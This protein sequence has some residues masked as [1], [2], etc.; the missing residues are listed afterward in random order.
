MLKLGI[1][2]LFVIYA[3]LR[4]FFGLFNH[5]KQN[6]KKNYTQLPCQI[7]T[8]T[9]Q[10]H[11]IHIYLCFIRHLSYSRCCSVQKYQTVS[12]IPSLLAEQMS[13][14]R[15]S[16]IKTHIFAVILMLIPRIFSKVWGISRISWNRTPSLIIIK[17]WNNITMFMFG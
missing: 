12:H 5:A 11:K 2:C 15:V 10:S 13:N 1:C 17:T 4:V 14:Q 9:L 7:S 16:D 8:K 3:I 6:K